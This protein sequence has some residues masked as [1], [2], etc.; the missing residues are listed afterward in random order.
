MEMAMKMV[1]MLAA[2]I[3]LIALF[4]CILNTGS[5]GFTDEDEEDEESN[6]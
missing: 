3:V 2:Y 4:V 6:N 5:E 1:F